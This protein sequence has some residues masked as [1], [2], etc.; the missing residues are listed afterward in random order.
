MSKHETDLAGSSA[1]FH[2]VYE[3][4]ILT[5]R[6]PGATKE[7]V[8]LGEERAAELSRL[9]RMFVL[10][11]TQEINS[12]YLPPKGSKTTNIVLRG[13]GSLRNVLAEYVRG[14]S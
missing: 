8:E 4:P 12:K 10:R 1:A 9:T 3:E 2:R 13:A 14:D 5:S 11:R 6:Q 7:V